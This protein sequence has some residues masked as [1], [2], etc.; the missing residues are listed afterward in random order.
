M[1]KV[2]C[3]LIYRYTY[4]INIKPIICIIFWNLYVKSF[5]LIE[6]TF[7]Y[8]H[9]EHHWLQQINQEQTE[10]FNPMAQ[11]LQVIWTVRRKTLYNQSIL[12][13]V[14]KWILLYC[15]IYDIFVTWWTTKL[16]LERFFWTKNYWHDC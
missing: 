5:L 15:H 7:I 2:G 11:D 6:I 1:P 10:E 13:I 3:F 16:K 8:I 4:R 12:W 14:C 9:Y